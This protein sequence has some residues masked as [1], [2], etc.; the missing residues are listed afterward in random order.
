MSATQA[1]TAQRK[2]KPSI[3]GKASG[4]GTRQTDASERT[5]RELRRRIL[6]NDLV[7]GADYSERQLEQVVGCSSAILRGALRR[8]ADE[9]LVTL[10]PRHGAHIVPMS[11]DDLREIFEIMIALEPIAARRV[12]LQDVTK[13]DL[14][15]LTAAIRQMD[16]ALIK[17][18]LV[19]WAKAD[20]LFH[21]RLIE[22]CGNKRLRLLLTACMDQRH[23]ARMQT[24]GVRP[25][26]VDSNRDHAAV[27]DA[28]RRHDADA[29][30]A[31]HHDHL[32]RSSAML[33]SLLRQVD[34][35]RH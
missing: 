3:R 15:R 35:G 1:R 32:A 17:D 25:P 11:L 8:L 6:D 31:L 12:A 4:A 29:A 19:A 7:P 21:A 22:L 26:P 9:G 5:Y 27:V 28:V 2:S 14:D 20:E 10:H 33:I 24:L 30:Y 18:D 23:R 13:A 16:A 34:A